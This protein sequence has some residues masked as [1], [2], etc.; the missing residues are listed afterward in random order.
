V[1]ARPAGGRIFTVGVRRMW[2]GIGVVL[3]ATV[4]GFA[5]VGPSVDVE[6][7]RTIFDWVTETD[8]IE[9]ALGSDPGFLV[10][11]RIAYV[12][13]LGFDGW[14]FTIALATCAVKAVVLWRL[15]TDRTVLLAL[16]SSYLFWL[17]EYTQIRIALA[18]GLVMLGIYAARRW[19]W[20]LFVV[21]ATLHAS[22]L[23]V[24]VLYVT[25]RYP[26]KALAA[27]I[28]GLPVLYASGAQS[29]LFAYLAIRVGS[30]ALLLD[31]GEFDQLNIF[32]LMPMVQGLMILLALCLRDRLTEPGRMELTFATVGLVSFYALSF[33]PVLA[34][35][36]YE[37]FIPFLLILVSRLWRHSVLMRVL[38][39]IY[40]AL[41]LRVSFIGS[42][43]LLA[44][45]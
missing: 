30:Y 44:L 43:S 25:T 19:E 35:R 10:L 23:A 3:A 21:A 16:Y 37:L 45:F 4:A 20:L 7:Y 31:Q 22:V 42:A 1:A 33:L 9:L 14:M 36:T 41:G 29:D 5:L 28:I 17:H 12:A 18:L 38:G 39:V 6:N 8:L 13:G 11:S 2:Y 40:I 26:R 15:P 32:S 27:A 24:V 34:F